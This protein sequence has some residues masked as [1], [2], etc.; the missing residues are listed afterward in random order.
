MRILA[1]MM[2][3]YSSLAYSLPDELEIWFLSHKSTS[4]LDKDEALK[5]G[6]KILE[7]PLTSSLKEFIEKWRR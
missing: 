4:L 6:A 3:F 5:Q 7:K 2:I 1:I